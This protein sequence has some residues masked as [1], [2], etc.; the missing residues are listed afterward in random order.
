MRLP[1]VSSSTTS[2]LIVPL[3]QFKNAENERQHWSKAIGGEGRNR[4][5]SMVYRSAL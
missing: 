3:E 2:L 1:T 4:D 5:Q